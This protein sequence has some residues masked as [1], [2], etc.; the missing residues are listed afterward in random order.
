LGTS[1]GNVRSYLDRAEM[2]LIF[3]KIGKQLGKNLRQLN[4]TQPSAAFVMM[5][6]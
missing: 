6:T 1:P 5:Y 3:V 4:S 2:I